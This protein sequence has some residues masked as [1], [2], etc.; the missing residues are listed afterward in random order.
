MRCKLI[1]ALLVGVAVFWMAGN[2]EIADAQTPAAAP[3]LSVTAAVTPTEPLTATGSLTETWFSLTDE[4]GA[5]SLQFP[6]DWTAAQSE[7]SAVLLQGPAHVLAYV[8]VFTVPVTQTEESAVGDWVDGVKPA[9]DQM[10]EQ[11]TSDQ[12]GRWD[13]GISGA[14]AHV[15]ATG[16]KAS[17]E[18]LFVVSRQSGERVVGASYARTAGSLTE[19]DLSRLERIL[20][21][22]KLSP[23][24]DQ[25]LA[26]PVT[27]L[28]QRLSGIGPQERVP[29]SLLERQATF[30][31]TFDGR[32][33]FAVWLVDDQG[34]RQDLLVNQ[35]GPLNRIYSLGIPR[36]GDYA[37]EVSGLG[38]WEIT[39]HQ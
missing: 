34:Q 21:S 11:I 9:W 18:Q 10:G 33:T 31:L 28:N 27:F 4:G 36:T 8:S 30:Q 29:V 13:R 3:A 1:V 7:P 26:P 38:S 15:T 14:V 35:A 20:A 37:F 6:P 17:M 12:R 22:L 24:V 32:S 19:D 5:F 2:I 16:S 25:P 39:V 23:G